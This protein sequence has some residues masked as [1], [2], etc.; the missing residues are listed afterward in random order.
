MKRMFVWSSLLLIVLVLLFAPSIWAADLTTISTQELKS[1]LDSKEKFLIVNALSDIEFAMEHIPGSINICVGNIKT[2][3][4]LPKD[5]E[6]LI[7]F[8]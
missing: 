1:K 4:R 2:T 7:V 5:K 8:Y 6:T 3:D